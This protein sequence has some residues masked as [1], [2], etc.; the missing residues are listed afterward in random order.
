MP[1]IKPYERKRRIHGQ[2]VNAKKQTGGKGRGWRD[3]AKISNV[4]L[5]LESTGTVENRF[6]SA[7]E[8]LVQYRI[9]RNIAEVD[10]ISSTIDPNRCYYCGCEVID[11]LRTP[12]GHLHAQAKTKD[13]IVPR[14]RGGRKTVTCCH[15][16]NTRKGSLS[17][18]EFRSKER[19]LYDQR[20]W[21]EK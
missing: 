21:A 13:H 17:I 1:F 16:C 14:T 8:N 15:R 9:N 4:Q 3:A 11:G 7:L 18:D 6:A 10:K 19:P 12:K 5:R 20:F 2:S